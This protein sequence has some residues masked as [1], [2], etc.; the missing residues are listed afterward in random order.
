MKKEAWILNLDIVPYEK[1]FELQKR[2][3]KMRSQEVINDI[4]ILL[5]HPPVFTV[6][7][8]ATLDN[9][10]ASPDELKGKGISVCKTNRG[11]DITYHGPGQLVG[12][13]IM[14]LKD[15]GK[16]LH[17]YIRT[18]EE[19]II[20][21]LMDY[22]IS[23]HRDKIHP[24]VWVG[25]EKIAAIGIAVKS[26]WTTMHGFALNINPDLNH[27][28]LIVPCGIS[29]RGVTSLSKLLGKPISQKEV[30]QKLIQHY[31]DVFN[32]NTKNISLEDI[33]GSN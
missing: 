3:V 11:G 30:R 16:D 31:Q 20:S 6:T 23:A 2:L 25:N 13:P 19:M 17:K 8:K 24:G 28:A 29:D 12:Y 5:E 26:S 7:R 21:L 1:A 18:I 9:I 14:D 27:Y 32:V 15:Y 33:N 22:S 4:L 10:L